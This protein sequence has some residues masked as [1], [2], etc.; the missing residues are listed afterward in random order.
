MTEKKGKL[1]LEILLQV[2]EKIGLNPNELE[3]ESQM[4]SYIRNVLH[5]E[6]MAK[7]LNVKAVPA[8]VSYGKTP[9]VGVQCLSHLQQL[10]DLH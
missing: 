4:V 10:I 6:E 7:Q 5:D 2:A 3:T 8:Y 1:I 9:A